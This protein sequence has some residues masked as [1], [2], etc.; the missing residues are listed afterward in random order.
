MNVEY[1]NNYKL[2]LNIKISMKYDDHQSEKS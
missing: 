1:K 2:N